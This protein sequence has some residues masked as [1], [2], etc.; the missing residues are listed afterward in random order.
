VN[1][2]RESRA[3]SLIGESLG[4][5]RWCDVADRAAKG[6]TAVL[7]IDQ[8][9]RD[10]TTQAA[11]E[12]RV[13]RQIDVAAMPPYADWSV[14]I[15]IGLAHDSPDHGQLWDLMDSALNGAVAL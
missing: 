2:H 15:R 7:G 1:L 14:W 9:I 11:L 6:R 3:N 5:E 12:S 10:R 4:S 8:R 13:E